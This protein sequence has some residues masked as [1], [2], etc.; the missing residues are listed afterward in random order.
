V[1][2]P[3]QTDERL[4]FALNGNQP[5]RERMCLAV[6]ALDRT[7]TDIRP[8]RPEGGPDG[9]RDI[10]C[11]RNSELCFGAVGFVNNVSDSADDKSAAK[12]KFK[13]DLQTALTTEP[14]LRA[15]VFFTNVDLTPNEVELLSQWGKE[16]NVTFIDIYWRE[17]IRIALDNPE[18]LAIRF[19]YLGLKLSDAE[20]TSFF[21]RFGNDL[22]KLVTGRFDSIERKIDAL[23]FTFWTKGVLREIN[24]E[25]EFYKQ[26]DSRR[27]SPEH[28]RVFLLLQSSLGEKRSVML[29]GRDDFWSVPNY[30][31]QFDTKNF[32][33]RERDTIT[34]PI[35]VQKGSRV[36]SG[37][38]TALRF[39]Y[40][41]HPQSPV[42]V[43]EFE[44]LD[45]YLYVTKNLIE[46]VKSVKLS[47]DS[48]VLIDQKIKP[49]AWKGVVPSFVWPG[50]LTSQEK[51]IGWQWQELFGWLTLDRIPPKVR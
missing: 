16:K 19:Q 25:L 5:S 40:K 7:Y 31:W 50:E 21:S 44:N 48:Y 41:W 9:G 14:K 38:I 43:I 11:L 13:S 20:Q 45:S 1:D 3:R 28:F 42:Q 8:R 36:G 27:D 22:E 51:E 30:G 26:E 33:W 10:Q 37:I 46:R 47:I 4:R 2:I 18:G 15:F 34:G 35:W 49:E 29:G 17:R 12:N 39:N 23:E 6:L 24:L 32:F